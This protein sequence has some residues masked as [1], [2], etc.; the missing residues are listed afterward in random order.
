M[1]LRTGGVLVSKRRPADGLY[2]ERWFDDA[3][4]GYVARGRSDRPRGGGAGEH[5]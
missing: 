4:P 1:G 2:A 5:R 3:M